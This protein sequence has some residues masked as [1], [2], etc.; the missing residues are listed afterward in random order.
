MA[1]AAKIFETVGAVVIGRNEGER[2]RRCLSSLSRV[3]VVIYVDSGS[4][5]GSAQWAREHR[6]EVIELDMSRPFTAARARNNGFQ[7]LREKWSRLG[8][9]RQRPFS[10]RVPK[11]APCAEGGASATLKDR[12]TTGYAIENGKG[13]QAKFANAAGM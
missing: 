5:D 10:I 7:R 11:W 9:L 13:R 4:T 1:N 12:S 2:L 8:F 6:A 3:P